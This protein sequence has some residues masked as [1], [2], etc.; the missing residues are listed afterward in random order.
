MV[1]GVPKELKTE[2]NRVALTPAGA[3]AFIAHG[4]QQGA[5]QASRPL[6]RG[7]NVHAGKVTHPGVASAL[8]MPLVSV[9]EV[10]CA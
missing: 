10:L 5:M 7:L 4:H 9:D 1:V 6:A 3:A 2:E 8:E